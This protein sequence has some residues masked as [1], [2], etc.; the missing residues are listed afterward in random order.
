MLLLLLML[1]MKMTPLPPL[2]YTSEDYWETHHKWTAPNSYGFIAEGSEFVCHWSLN[3]NA[4]ALHR[5]RGF[6][7]HWS[8]NEFFWFLFCNC[9]ELQSTLEVARALEKQ[10]EKVIHTLFSLSGTISVSINVVHSSLALMDPFKITFSLL[11]SSVRPP[12]WYWYAEVMGL[13]PNEARKMPF[14]ASCSCKICS[15]CLHSL[16]KPEPNVC[17]NLRAGHWKPETQSRVLTSLK[18][19]IL[20]FTRL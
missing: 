10:R 15:L 2:L 14:Q 20:V 12:Q 18:I 16:V 13:N 11:H 4:M 7:S 1:P 19:L 3:D 9:A 5:G 8:F 6:V 17:E